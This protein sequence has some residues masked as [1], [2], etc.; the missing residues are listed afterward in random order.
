MVKVGLSSDNRLLEDPDSEEDWVRD[1]G[2]ELT[3]GYLA[4]LE[5]VVC[6]MCKGVMSGD[7]VSKALMFA[8]NRRSLCT[9]LNRRETQ[10]IKSDHPIFRIIIYTKFDGRR[11]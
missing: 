1:G 11:K 2:G 4:N 6:L 5:Q 9:D 10:R 8:T 3:L 7:A